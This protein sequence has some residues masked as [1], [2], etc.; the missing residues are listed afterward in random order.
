M[1]MEMRIKFTV[2]KKAFRLNSTIKESAFEWQRDAA[3]KSTQTAYISI[4]SNAL[5]FTI[6]RLLINYI[7][8]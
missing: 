1:Y 4:L 2:Q 3:I 6:F 5:V 7:T 8:V